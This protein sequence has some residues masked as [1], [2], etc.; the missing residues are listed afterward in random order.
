M[1]QQDHS[2]ERLVNEMFLQTE[3]SRLQD[4]ERPD[5]RDRGTPVLKPQET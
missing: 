4:N 3:D 5:S 1:D 2:V